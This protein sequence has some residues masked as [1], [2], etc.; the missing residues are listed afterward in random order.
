MTVINYYYCRST[1]PTLNNIDG[2]SIASK[3]TVTPDVL[4]TKRVVT[5]IEGIGSLVTE[6][7][8]TTLMVAIDSY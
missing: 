2:T 5:G 6:A 1:K 3:F 8:V 4:I 7:G